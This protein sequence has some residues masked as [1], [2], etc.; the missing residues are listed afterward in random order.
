MAQ[1]EYTI[2]FE[3]F[4]SSSL[5]DAV[6][7]QLLQSAFDECNNAYAPYSNFKVGAAILL[8]DLKV[9]TGNNQENAS[10]PCGICAERAAL[11]AYGLGKKNNPILK[12]AVSVLTT[13]YI[14]DQPPSPCGLCR[15]VLVEFEELNPNPIEIILGQ[16]GM[17]CFVFQSAKDLLPLHFGP[18]Y[19][20]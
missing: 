17:K 13:H 6:Q 12:L 2:R 14:Q 3:E 7:Q 15:Q 4:E 11:F 20:K 18:A 10:Y 1:V 16:P 9:L 8:K 5:L 19:L